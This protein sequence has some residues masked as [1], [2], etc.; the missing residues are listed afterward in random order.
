MFVR[1]KRIFM[2]KVETIGKWIEMKPLMSPSFIFDLFMVKIYE[3]DGFKDIGLIDFLPVSRESSVSI[4]AG[5]SY[6]LSAHTIVKAPLESSCLKFIKCLVLV[7]TTKISN[8]LMLSSDEYCIINLFS[9]S[10]QMSCERRILT[11]WYDILV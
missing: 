9:T 11:S 1:S 6:E 3:Y 7:T 5:C 2:R 4:L 8:T 10:N